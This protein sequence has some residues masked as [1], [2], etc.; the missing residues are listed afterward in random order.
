MVG[1]WQNGHRRGSRISGTT[2]LGVVFGLGQCDKENHGW[3]EGLPLTVPCSKFRSCRR[4]FTLRQISVER[5]KNTALSG[6]PRP[7][8]LLST[9]AG[10][11]GVTVPLDRTRPNRSRCFESRFRARLWSIAENCRKA[12]LHAD[13]LPSAATPKPAQDG[14][15]RLRAKSPRHKSGW[16]GVH[17][18]CG[19]LSAK[20]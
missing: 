4:A 16:G 5:E 13:L 15:G 11:C 2:R 1:R 10:Y 17:F 12:N 18:P 3:R 6:S 9:L 14:G 19:R 20:P 8:L 7:P